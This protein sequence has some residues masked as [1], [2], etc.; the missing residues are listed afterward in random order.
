[1]TGFS[2]YSSQAVLNWVAGL[3]A[4][5]A[6][7]AVWLA[8]FTAVGADD[9]TGFTE[10]SG[11]SYARVQIAGNAATNNTTA[12]GNATLHFASTPAW[13]VAGMTATD[14]TASVIPA[15]TTV[16]ST[17]SNTVVLSANATGGGVGN[18]DT[19][20]FSAFGAASGT[21]PST[22]VSTAA[23][24]FAQS[25]A[26]G[27]FGTIEAFGLYDALTSGNLLDWDY[28]GNYAWLPVEVSSAS[29]GILT[30]HAHGY[31]AADPIVFTTEYGG[32]APTFSQSNFTGVLAVVS[33]ATDSFSVTNAS[34]AVNTSSTGSGMI[35]KIVQQ[36]TVANMVLT[37][38]AGQLTL[39]SA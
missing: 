28:I 10:A 34:T 35:R 15:G 37:F 33:P 5:P 8:L 38:A 22:S 6:L 11:N 17:T 25:G 23:V 4:M 12:S 13:I 14:A 24:S 26:G 30:A 9:G 27:G 32:T 36:A 3:K 19:I 1:M 29:P 2:N 7:P 39:V 31:S 16:L 18:G 21:S 20:E